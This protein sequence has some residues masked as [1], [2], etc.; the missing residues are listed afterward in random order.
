MTCKEIEIL[1]PALLEGELSDDESRRVRDHLVKCPS[2]SKALE[3]LKASGEIVRNLEEVEPPPWLKTRVMA[4]VREEAGQK[5]SIFRKLFYPLHIK[6]PIQALATALIAVAAWN[7][8]KTGEPE[9]RQIAPPPAAVQEVPRTQAPSE[10]VKTQEPAPVQPALKKEFGERAGIREK[11]ARAPSPAQVEDQKMR[12]EPT[13]REEA[14]ADFA[15]PAESMN[16]ARPAAA[17]PKDEEALRGAGAMRQPEMD[18][19]A[20]A[21]ARDQRQ[22]ALKAPVGAMAKE[23]GKQEAPSAASPMLSATAPAQPLLTMIL[24][25]RHPGAAAGDVED[26]LK[27][28]GGQAVRRQT[29]EGR[30]TLSATIQS[31]KLE[32]FREKL[33]GL[34][35]IEEKPSASPLPA[36]ALSIRIDIL[37]E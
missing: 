2:C 25:S 28:H 20:Q 34:G 9:F 37:P 17:P 30:E 4:R 11:K 5:E 10:P 23:S 29:L 32:A 24:H 15:K 13:V 35:K 3:N 19:A 31:D 8:Y 14:K 6:I 33:K 18:R 12:Q 1:L 16:A 7:V 27:K 22:K 36:G 21:P 26:L